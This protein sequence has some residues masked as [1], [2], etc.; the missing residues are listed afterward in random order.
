MFAIHILITAYNNI[1]SIPSEMLANAKFTTLDMNYNKITS[2]PS[3]I[4]LLTNLREL[5]LGE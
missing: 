5:K 4:G 2:V 1:T 3:D